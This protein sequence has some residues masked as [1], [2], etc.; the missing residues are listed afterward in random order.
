MTQ[1]TKCLLISII[2][3]ISAT[4]L[5]Q[6]TD[7][8]MLIQSAFYNGD[9]GQWLL[10]KSDR[11]L[12]FVFYAGIKGLLLGALKIQVQHLWEIMLHGKNLRAVEY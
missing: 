3:L 12:R 6:I 4:L 7:V 11:V 9:T 2:T 5:F 10:T 1:P 8:D